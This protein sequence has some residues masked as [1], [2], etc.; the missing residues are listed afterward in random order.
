MKSLLA[1]C[2]HA[3]RV[4]LGTP[5][6]SGIAVV[7]LAIGIAFV[8]AF[9]S[10]YSD[11]VLK[12]H[13]GFEDSRGLVTI[14]QNDGSQLSNISYALIERMNAEVGSLES[15]VGFTIG[16]EQLGPD[17]EQQPFEI[18]T[19]G[20]FDG[21]RPRVSLGRGFDER[22]HT[23]DAELVTVIS[24]DFWKTHFGGTPDVIGKT[25][26]IK[27]TDPQAPRPPNEPPP[28]P[29]E[30]TTAFRIIGVM[31]PALPSANGAFATLWLPFE[32]V[33]PLFM[34]ELERV[35]NF[36]QFQTLGRR[37]DGASVAAVIA[38]LN[39]RY[40]DDDEANLSPG[41]RLDAIEGV[42]RDLNLKRDLE[43]QLSLFLTGSVLLAFVAAANVSLFLL[44]RA[45]GRR[46]ELGIR[47]AVGAPLQRLGRQLATEAALLVG[48]ATL[49]G[50]VMSFWLGQWLKSIAFLRRANWAN[51]TLFDWRVIG[52]IVVFVLLL[53][54]LVSL[55][56]VLGIKRLGIAS[57]SREIR[58][59]ANL[60][61]RIAS[62]VQI[63]IAAAVG[64]AALAFGWYL[65]L[66]MTQDRGYDVSNLYVVTP[67]QAGTPG[68]IQANND[69]AGTLVQRGVQRAAILGLPGVTAVGF[70]SAAPGINDRTLT[71]Q[72]PR[73]SAPDETVRFNAV[74]SD[75]ELLEMLGV[76]L[77]AG[78]VFDGTETDGM[79]ANETAAELLWGRTDVVGETLPISL[80]DAESSE[81]IGV[82][83]D[84]SL[85]HPSEDPAP[86]VYLPVFPF[87]IGGDY[88][89]IRTTASQGELR[90]Q[91][92]S[93]VDA[94]DLEITIGDVRDVGQQVDNLLAPDR[95]RSLLT[96][97]TALLVLLLAGFGFYG[98]QRF[99]VGAGRREYAIRASLGA[100]PK[101]LGRLVLARGLVL[102]V[103]GLILGVL[104]AFVVAAW[105]RD[106]FVSREVSAPVIT[107]AV[108]AALIV[109]LLAA[110]VGPAAM[111]RRTQPAPL[112]KQD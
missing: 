50:L 106:D 11:L 97:G 30:R 35:R 7:V 59:R 3:L 85:G 101:A 52:G 92:Q 18:V 78:R 40:L 5:V 93:L 112:L 82:L 21:L 107:L 84:I 71:A 63:A 100:G 95:A 64:A 29:E 2:R 99:L 41:Y 70:G 111:A 27:S 44:S 94:G 15:I 17:F 57:S 10:L 72:I 58:T 103:P 90:E 76:K 69:F 60:T 36:T 22:D 34:G 38:E 26:E 6:A 9:L 67:S 16:F 88:I 96:V 81:I 61:Q 32:R 8:G 51:A 77:V 109:L 66:L 89:F 74:A 13:P 39:D 56:P 75:R 49:L 20:F 28:A 108:L 42:V 68:A 4:Y 79:M 98:T 110:S 53:T 62:T 47:M 24:D 65:V 25:V 105:L 73:P 12:P 91:L 19:K 80:S 46:R 55:A 23:P 1:D 87:F 104:L 102:G 45:P 48:A 33:A 37:S 86:L 83:S 31:D 54:V 43:R 14:G